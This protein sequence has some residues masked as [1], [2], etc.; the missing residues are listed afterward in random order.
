[1][2]KVSMVCTND[3]AGGAARASFRLYKGL[4]ALDVP[5][6]I[7]A[8]RKQM[9]NDTIHQV[10]NVFAEQYVARAGLA[11]IQEVF[12]DQGRTEMSN[13][14]FTLSYP[15]VDV[16]Q[17]TPVLDAD[18]VNLH[19]VSRLLSVTSLRKLA[20]LNKPIVWTL[21]D[22]WAFTGGCHYPAGCDRYQTDCH[23]CPQ[24][25]E[26]PLDLPARVLQDKA[27]LWA[28]LPLTIVTPSRWLADCV[29]KSAP[30]R[31]HRVEVI[32]YGLETDVFHPTPKPEAKQK[33]GLPE[34]AIAIL[35]GANDSNEIR[36]GFW[37]LFAALQ[38]CEANPQFRA[39]AEAGKVQLICFGP[40]PSD[41]L[42]TLS[43]PVRA[44]GMIEDDDTLSCLYSAADLLVLPSQEDN[45]PNVMLEA[46]SC[47]TPVVAFDT[48]G[49]PDAVI[50]GETGL[51]VPPG[52]LD[53]LAAAI[54][55]L[56]FNE[57]QRQKLSQNGRQ[58]TL[59]NYLLVRQAKDYMELFE[60]LVT[61][62]PSPANPAPV[63]DSSAVE[64]DVSLGKNFG[65]I[66]PQLSYEALVRDNLDYRM[67]LRQSQQQVEDLEAELGRSQGR[68]S[69][70]ETSK[71]WRIRTSWMMWR[72]R[73]GLGGDA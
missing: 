12:I 61:T 8:R 66:Y 11:A 72:K 31:H 44:F 26:N 39:L 24:L 22:C 57:A 28:D 23:A 55:K 7:T 27:D 52:D 9:P 33:M 73:L 25:L 13:T 32:P 48:G 64:L 18:V 56:V 6:S 1:M 34:G 68:I 14:L 17:F 69:A 47:A 20:Q 2:M 30:L 50:D 58:R 5:V 63:E 40:P 41:E 65:A 35:I 19:W 51:L 62:H 43:V 60:E 10:Q 3:I 46:M 59:D 42:Q 29:R 49:I 4:Q 15:G 38:R 36:K 70:M 16:T 71:F 37:A 21:H 54:L 53:A 67:K 45:L